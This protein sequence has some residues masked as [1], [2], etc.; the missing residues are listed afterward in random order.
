MVFGLEEMNR[1]S[2]FDR[3]PRTRL[4]Q[5]PVLGSGEDVSSSGLE[6]AHDF[7][8]GSIGPQHVLEDILRHEQFERVVLERQ[9]FEVFATVSA[10]LLSSSDIIEEERARVL[11]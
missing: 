5:V 10:R 6:H 7:S 2:L 1:L 8:N 9:L 11:P 4:G 3:H